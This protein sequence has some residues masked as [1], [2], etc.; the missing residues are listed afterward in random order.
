[1]K[2]NSNKELNRLREQLE[3]TEFMLSKVRIG[4]SR[5]DLVEI[6]EM[7]A[8]YTMRFGKYAW[9]SCWENQCTSSV[10]RKIV[11]Q[12]LSIHVTALDVI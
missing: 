10:T 9:K 3:E 4:M 7:K 8:V 1:M 12:M 6:G 5:R 11:N 2:Q